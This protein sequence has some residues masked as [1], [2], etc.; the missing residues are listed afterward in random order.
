[1]CKHSYIVKS[2]FFVYTYVYTIVPSD[3]YKIY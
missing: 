3:E 2:T 1:M